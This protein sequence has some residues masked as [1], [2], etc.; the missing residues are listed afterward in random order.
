MF[1]NKLEINEI[2]GPTIQ[3][4]GSAAGRHCL[5]IRTFQCNLECT[6]CDT[7]KTWAVTPEKAARTE[8]K[9][10]FFVEEQRTLM[11]PDEIIST[12]LTKWDVRYRP[13]N[14]IVS[15]GEP[16]MQAKKLQPV[17]RQL[18]D[19]GNKIHI[20]TAG[21]IATF[22]EFDVTVEQYNISPKLEHSGNIHKK[23]YKPSALLS[24]MQTGK[25]HFKFVIRNVKDLA[26]V[27]YIATDIGIP[28]QRIMVMPEGSSVEG[29]VKIAQDIIDAAL[30]RG[31]GLSFRS[32]ILIW[33]DKE[34]V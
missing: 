3:G 33:G 22:P 6:W 4:E 8:S 17:T 27:D 1:N 25:A 23:R 2:F 13:T 26:E 16:M 21:T 5:F 9:K 20:E 14:I 7:A 30:V 28:R 31:Y 29:N 18:F 10:R 32:H 11:A 24:L 12:L 15:G 19:W 34:G